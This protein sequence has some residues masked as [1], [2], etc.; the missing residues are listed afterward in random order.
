MGF[1]PWKAQDR[2]TAHSFLSTRSHPSS[3][4]HSHSHCEPTD[5]DV[6]IKDYENGDM[7]MASLAR[8]WKER[9][10]RI[11][12]GLAVMEPSLGAV[13]AATVQDTPQAQE[14]STRKAILEITTEVSMEAIMEAR[15]EAIREA[16]WEAIMEVPMEVPMEVSMEVT[17]EVP[18]E[19][20]TEANT[21][22]MME[23][24]TEVVLL[25][26]HDQ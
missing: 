13:V 12:L 4:S 7:E 16:S 2:S 5:V 8:G 18:M 6:D 17:M 14:L 1:W 15:E 23:V 21:V 26:M 19:A 11:I 3:D 24:T 22:A 25:V 10:P 9:K 20:A